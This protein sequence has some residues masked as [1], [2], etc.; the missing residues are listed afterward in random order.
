MKLLKGMFNILKDWTGYLTSVII[1]TIGWLQQCK[2]ILD[3][4]FVVLGCIG[5]VLS[6]ILTTKKIRKQ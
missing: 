4:I 3:V 2:D 5:L 1:G 6:I